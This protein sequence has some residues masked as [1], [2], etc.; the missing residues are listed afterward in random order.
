MLGKFTKIL[1]LV[2]LFGG[3]CASALANTTTAGTAVTAPSAFG[4]SSGVPAAHAPAVRITQNDISIFSG[5]MEKTLPAPAPVL[6]VTS[7]VPEKPT[8]V[9]IAL[10]LPLR[11]EALG[12]AAAAVRAGFLAAHDT[13]KDGA[14]AITVA[15]TGDATQ[16]VL[17]GY[18]RAVLSHDI[19]VGPL[20]RSGVTAIAQR[21]RL[22]KPTIALTQTD[23]PGDADIA[24]PEKMLVMG[25]SV[26]DE[27]RQVAI[28]AHD[29][30]IAEKAFSISTNAA[31]Q[32]R[33]AKA[34]SIQWQRLG[35]ASELMELGVAD[36][37]LNANS[38]AQLR[39]RILAEKPGMVFIA[40]DAVQARQLREAIGN[41]MP[42]FG[43]SQLNPL[44]QSDWA[45]A[46]RDPI[47]DGVRLV[48]LPW[49]L[50]R[51]HAAVMI[52]PRPVAGAGDKRSADLERLYAL[53]I[54]AYRVAREIAMK[55]PQIE[56]D[57]VTGK[58]VI[59]FGNGPA[60]FDRIES[61]AIYQNGAVV[62][63]A[64]VQ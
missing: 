32:R 7:V 49:Q 31:W 58:L 25:L 57:G 46:E 60:H 55:R 56:I 2:S 50:Q 41:E 40:L 8:Q 13:E 19:V 17:A 27:A 11:S 63:L 1:L 3:L 23:T 61:P 24:L 6:Q 34:F 52:Y 15:E 16:D 45:I 53:G 36:G 18:D 35:L 51:D 48:D 4:A 28:W 9:R 39:R 44:A 42:L 20:T 22:G 21:G 14:L 43:T 30:K 62:P 12:Q 5:P 37:N 38:L 33:A 47:L 64:G 59:E 29:D 26:E 10:L 54:D